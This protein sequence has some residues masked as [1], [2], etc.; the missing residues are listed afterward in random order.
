V[1]AGAPTGP[2][3]RRG[4]ARRVRSRYRVAQDLPSSVVL[5]VRRDPYSLI[6]QM[7]SSHS[8]LNNPW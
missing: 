7:N 5:T 4:P 1:L 8:C 2:G 3:L 6:T